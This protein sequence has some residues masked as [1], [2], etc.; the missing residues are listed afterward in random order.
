MTVPTES[1]GKPTSEQYQEMKAQDFTFDAPP[2]AVG[3]DDSS[4][5][6]VDS[7]I[8]DD[9][10]PPPVQSQSYMSYEDRR[11]QNREEYEKKKYGVNPTPPPAPAPFAP[12]AHFEDSSPTSSMFTGEAAPKSLPSY[13]KIVKKN[14][15]GDTWEE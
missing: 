12:P 4:R 2:T 13:R 8:S 6:S 9:M 11:R 10:L 1:T 5:P 15:Y 3:L 14:E 7:V